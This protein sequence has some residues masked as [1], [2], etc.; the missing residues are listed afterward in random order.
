MQN[1]SRKIIQSVTWLIV[2]I[3]IS[4]GMKYPLIGFIVPIVMLMG[5]IGGIFNGRFVCGWLCPRGAFYD[6]VITHIS[7]SKPIPKFLRNKVFRWSV[8]SLLMGFMVFRILQDP[9][10][11][12]H[13]GKVFVDMCMITTGLGILLAIFI[14]PRTWCSFCPIGTIGH[15]TGGRKTQMNLNK[16]CA[17]CRVCEKACPMGLN[18]IDDM[19]DGKKIINDCLKCNECVQ[20]CPKGILEISSAN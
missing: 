12:Y 8:F 6:R 18:I 4:G 14:H 20:T 13:W 7:P 9:A 5:I 3:T 10:N 1:K 16:G 11:V 19:N 17:E 2:I 15:A